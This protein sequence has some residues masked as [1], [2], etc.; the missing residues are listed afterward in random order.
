MATATDGYASEVA[1]LAAAAAGEP[2]AVRSLLDL[3]GPVVYGFVLARVGGRQEVAEDLVQDTFL[4]AMR[5]APTFRGDA[6][7]ATWMCAIARHRLARHYAQE[8]RREATRTELLA[9]AA[10]A[11]DEMHAVDDRQEVMVALG[12]LPVLHRQVLVLK[13]LDG[14]SV[15]E[16]AEELGR[17]RVQVQSLLQRARHG[18]RRQLGTQDG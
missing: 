10:D 4:E 13:Y 15:E 7:V 1:L 12:R 6:L 14:R 11:P 18:L 9:V 8:R 5:S 2:A 16:I 3:A 17:G